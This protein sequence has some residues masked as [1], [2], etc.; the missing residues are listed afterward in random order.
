MTFFQ[1]LP[2]PEEPRRGRTVR[3]VPPVWA[4]APACE[5]PAVVH[6]GEF[7]YRSQSFIMAVEMAKVYST[8]CSFDLTWTLRRAGES[9]KAWAELNGAF[10]GHPHGMQAI[11]RRAFAALL[12]GVQLADGT[13]ARADSTLHG[14]YPP[15]SGQQ[16]EPPVLILRGNG[17]EGGDDEMS[18][19]A[20]LWL[21]PLPPAGDFRLVA[22]WTD[23]GM[24]E[25]SITLDG[26]QLNEAAAA[27]QKYWPEEGSL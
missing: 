21:W 5:L 6:I 14:R 2:V 18:G 11:E 9:D 16:P 23:M 3:Y 12:F 17:G 24:E 15:G 22:Q 1:D 8:G 27:T 25:T 19:K 10:F 7:I 4:G 20:S 26:A 13:K